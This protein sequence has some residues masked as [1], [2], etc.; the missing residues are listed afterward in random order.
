MLLNTATVACSAEVV[1]SWD[2]AEM[3]L[4]FLMSL[5]QQIIEFFTW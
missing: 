2:G 5:Y 1:A 4:K 3:Y